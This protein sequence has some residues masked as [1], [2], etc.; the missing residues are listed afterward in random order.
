M[1]LL[2]SCCYSS[3][4]QKLSI[5]AWCNGSTTEFDSV[6]KGSIPFATSK[7]SRYGVKV[8]HRAHNPKV[9]VRV[10]ISLPNNARVT[11]LV[12]CLTEDEK[13]T[14]SNHVSC[15]KLR[16]CSSIGRASHCHCEGRGIKTLQVRQTQI[17]M[18]IDM[19]P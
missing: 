11:Q 14:C 2:S 19:F 3:A 18:I 16:T 15:T 6:S 13:V 17:Q 7:L 10:W 8:A 4:D 12:E 9:P 1:N 5:V